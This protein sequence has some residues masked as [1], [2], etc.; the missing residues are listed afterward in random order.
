MNNFNNNNEPQETVRQ[1]LERV[2]REK[3]R[4]EARQQAL[5]Y[6][7]MV[8]LSARKNLS[9]DIVMSD[10]NLSPIQKIA[11]MTWNNYTGYNP[12]RRVG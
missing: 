4:E 12:L 3:E 6:A 9:N 7:D 11:N 5:E 1:T 8:K 2:W 10:K